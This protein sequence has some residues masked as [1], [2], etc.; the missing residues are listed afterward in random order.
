MTADEFLKNLQDGGAIISAE[1]CSDEDLAEARAE[2][3]I[4]ETPDGAAYVYTDL[5]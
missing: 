5:A 1:D 3:R 2:D 4:Y